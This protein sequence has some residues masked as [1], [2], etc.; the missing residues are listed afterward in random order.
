MLNSD[1]KWASTLDL[2]RT[3]YGYVMSTDV[4]G[5]GPEVLEKRILAL[6]LVATWVSCERGAP[7]PWASR[8][9]TSATPTITREKFLAWSADTWDAWQTMRPG[10]HL[11]LI[12]GGRAT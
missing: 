12:E 6:V 2:V 5:D 11:T 9:R 1:L 10:A 4:E 8:V 3:L 7:T